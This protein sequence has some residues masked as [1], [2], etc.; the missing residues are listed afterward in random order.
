MA[1]QSGFIAA[2]SNN[3]VKMMDP[4]SVG[5]SSQSSCPPDVFT[6][7]VDA[8]P[9]GPSFLN[10]DDDTDP[11][12]DELEEDSGKPNPPI[13][14][15]NS[16]PFF[17]FAQE[18]VANELTAGL[19][20]GDIEV[21]SQ[22]GP[23][24]PRKKVDPKLVDLFSSRLNQIMVE[25]T[26]MAHVSKQIINQGTPDEWA[27]EVMQYVPAA[28]TAMLLGAEPTVEDLI[29]LPWIDTDDVGVYGAVLVHEEPGHT[30][31][32]YVGSATQIAKGLQKRRE[33]RNPS[34]LKKRVQSGK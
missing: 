11:D 6:P 24:K 26:D 9:S 16:N 21:L 27:A 14:Q 33:D 13:F 34:R 4:V 17:L 3:E 10:L 1:Q 20:L 12:D 19:E 15:D 29:Q 7:R 2:Y 22:L 25:C 8:D 32:F 5:S 30:D 31:W 28:I 18:S 23:R